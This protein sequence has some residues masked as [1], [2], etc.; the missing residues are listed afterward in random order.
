MET[1]KQT[2]KTSQFFTEVPTKNNTFTAVLYL[3]CRNMKYTS[4]NCNI[5][6][7]LLTGNACLNSY[8]WTDENTSNINVDHK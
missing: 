5:N 3:S 8:K 6:K 7:I 2:N 1:Y 4:L